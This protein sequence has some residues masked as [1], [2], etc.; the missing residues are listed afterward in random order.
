MN[1]ELICLLTEAFAA[2]PEGEFWRA[3]CA[4]R[5]ALDAADT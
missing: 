3:L 5:E 1:I 4:L 2:G